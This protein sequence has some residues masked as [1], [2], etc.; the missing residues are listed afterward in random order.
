MIQLLR[1]V[2]IL[3]YFLSQNWNPLC[4][5]QFHTG[6][7]YNMKRQSPWSFVSTWLLTNINLYREDQEQREKLRIVFQ[8]SSFYRQRLLQIF[9]YSETFSVKKAPDVW[10][11]F[12]LGWSTCARTLSLVWLHLL[13]VASYHRVSV[14]SFP[15]EILEI[16]GLS[17]LINVF[18]FRS[19]LLLCCLPMVVITIPIGPC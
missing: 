10:I 5:D 7:V 9:C 13:V 19:T 17:A 15:Q 2:F 4:V 3:T 16:H 1:F 6:L 8:R 11:D 12:L 14:R 18:R